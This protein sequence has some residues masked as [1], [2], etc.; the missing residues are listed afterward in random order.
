MNMHLR[1]YAENHGIEL[2]KVTTTVVIDRSDPSKAT[3]TYSIDFSQLLS[4]EQQAKLVQ[5]AATCPVHN[6]LSREITFRQVA[7]SAG[8]V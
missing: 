4:S 1:M 3:F 7:K 8:A 5:I 6:T 2:G